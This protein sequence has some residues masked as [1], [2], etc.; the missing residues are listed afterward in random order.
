MKN[1]NRLAGVALAAVCL[2]ATASAQTNGPKGISVRLGA[3][4]PK[5]GDSSFAAGLDYKF[6][7]FA[8]PQARNEYVSYLGAS[9]DYYGKDGD[10]RNIPLALTYNVRA[11]QLV[12]SAGLGVDFSTYRGDDK[13]GLA[14][15]I[16]V[17][18]EFGQKEGVTPNPLFVSAKY[19]FAN[20]VD[21]GGF[22]IYVGYRF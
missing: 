12:F 15:Q 6:K 20:Q 1:T 18:Y 9:L 5:V 4:F 11:Q 16:G 7:E 19:Y 3:Q 10:N 8:V 21:L 2:A 13:T 17:A 22:A 14:G